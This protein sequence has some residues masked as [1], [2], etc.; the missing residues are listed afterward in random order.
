M[1]RTSLEIVDFIIFNGHISDS[2]IFNIAK[3]YVKR[4]QKISQLYGIRVI[5]IE[6]NNEVQFNEEFFSS[7]NPTRSLNLM[8]SN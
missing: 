4:V 8:S 2:S 3:V 5:C 7:R 6:L 1:I